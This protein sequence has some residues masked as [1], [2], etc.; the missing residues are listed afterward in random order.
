MLRVNDLRVNDPL[1][2]GHPRDVPHIDHRH[3]VAGLDR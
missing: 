2:L 1:T 3:R